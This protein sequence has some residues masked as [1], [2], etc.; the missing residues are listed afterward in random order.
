[1]ILSNNEFLGLLQEMDFVAD[2]GQRRENGTNPRDG[3]PNV[4]RRAR[5]GKTKPGED[6]GD[7]DPGEDDDLM[8]EFKGHRF[9]VMDG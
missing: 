8:N 1:M 6:Q 9:V 5:I 4:A 7:A 3:V 2:Q